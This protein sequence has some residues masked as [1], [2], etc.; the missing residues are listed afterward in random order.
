MADLPV[1]DLT[2]DAN[3]DWIKKAY[4]GGIEKYRKDEALA[5]DLAM[6]M[7]RARVEKEKK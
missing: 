5:H 6:E 1:I 3:D 7:H 4:P 2:G